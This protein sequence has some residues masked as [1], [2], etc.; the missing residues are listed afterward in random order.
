MQKFKQAIAKFLTFAIVLSMFSGFG[1]GVLTAMAAEF[2]SNA[3]PS[4]VYLNVYLQQNV[5]GNA[6]MGWTITTADHYRGEARKHG[7]TYYI[8]GAAAYNGSYTNADGSGA[9]SG[10][11]SSTDLQKWTLLTDPVADNVWNEATWESVSIPLDYRIVTL[12]GRT[13]TRG[14]QS[15]LI[16]NDGLFNFIP[17]LPQADPDDSNKKLGVKYTVQPG[18][19][20]WGIAW[21]YYGTMS[22]AK[23]SEITKANKEYFQQTRNILEAGATINLPARGI[24]NPVTITHLDQAVGVYRVRL[25]DTIADIAIKYYGSTAY[26][27]KIYEANKDRIQKIGNSY[28]I[29]EQQWLVITR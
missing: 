13:V 1:P 16:T 29:Y 24:R 26:I 23:V 27:G 3:V 28:M 6:Y 9:Y 8:D 5:S 12:G 11:F 25:N 10:Y 18:D 21:N 20:R 17:P 19:Q 14:G 2:L 22:D 7:D 15:S 4:Q